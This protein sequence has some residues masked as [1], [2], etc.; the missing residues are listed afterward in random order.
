ME[1][2]IGDRRLKQVLSEGETKGRLRWE[3]GERKVKRWYVV[4]SESRR[5]QEQI[6]SVVEEVSRKLA[7]PVS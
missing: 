6:G 2:K 1:L 4:D 7:K 3:R 5:T